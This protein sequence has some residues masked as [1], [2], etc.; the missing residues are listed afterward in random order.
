M[1]QQHPTAIFAG[2]G[3][4]QTI[5]FTKPDGTGLFGIA[6]EYLSGTDD[7]AVT[8]ITAPDGTLLDL[9]AIADSDIPTFDASTLFTT[10]DYIQAINDAIDNE[11]IEPDLAK[12]LTEEHKLFLAT[13][14]AER[15]AS[16]LCD[17]LASRGNSFID[18]SLG[19]HLQPLLEELAE[20]YPD[21][22][23][24]A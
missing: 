4:R 23:I 6:A 18:E 11:D 14:Y 15:T 21:L 17:V 10:A 9:P 2:I 3:S 12:H 16:T 20:R 8:T 1:S 13:A 5:L 22:P 7:K 24:S 19:N